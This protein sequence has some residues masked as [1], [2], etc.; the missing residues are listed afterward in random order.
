MINDFLSWAVTLLRTLISWLGS[1][2]V[3]AGV[4]MIA[5]LAGFFVIG[6][7][8]KALVYKGGS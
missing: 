4:S 8:I 2:E 3:V 6:L 7:L 5:L 1:M